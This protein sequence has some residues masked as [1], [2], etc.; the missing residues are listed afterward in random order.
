M[1]FLHNHRLYKRFKQINVKIFVTCCYTFYNN[2]H[3]IYNVKGLM[4]VRTTHITDA[5]AALATVESNKVLLG[6]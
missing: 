5:N 4:Y 6:L 3:V 1:S 2:S